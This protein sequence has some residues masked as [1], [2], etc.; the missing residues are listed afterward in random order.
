MVGEVSF[1]FHPFFTSLTDRNQYPASK[2]FNSACYMNTLLTGYK[3]KYRKI[4]QKLNFSCTL[5]L[6]SAPIQVTHN[7]FS[8]TCTGHVS[9]KMRKKKPF[10]KL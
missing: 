3:K 7:T 6:P 5:A 10:V 4:V 8:E 1:L 2:N 9:F